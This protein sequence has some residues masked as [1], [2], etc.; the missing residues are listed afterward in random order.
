MNENYVN[1]FSLFL[2]EDSEKNKDVEEIR[3]ESESKFLN[4]SGD[5]MKGNLN[6]NKNKIINNKIDNR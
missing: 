5:Y 3:I 1:A 2:N 6:M 4:V